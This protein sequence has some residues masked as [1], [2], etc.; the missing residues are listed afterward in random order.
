[1]C[2]NMNIVNNCNA[3][4]P[5]ALDHFNSCKDFVNLETDALITAATLKV[6]WNGK[7]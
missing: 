1:M 7:Y 5:N 4:T 3:K 2:S 6:F